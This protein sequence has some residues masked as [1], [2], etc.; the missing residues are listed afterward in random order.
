MTNQNN[1]H[2]E[3]C[4]G[5]HAVKCVV[6]GSLRQS[7]PGVPERFQEPTR[8]AM[9]YFSENGEFLAEND[10]YLAQK[11]TR[12]DETIDGLAAEIERLKKINELTQEK[13]MSLELERDRATK[14][15]GILSETVKAKDAEISRLAES[16]KK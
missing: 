11:I 4:T 1:N 8:I 2:I 10:P 13:N 3:G 5:A 14:R 15:I 12:S 9:V 7:R 16:K 6:A